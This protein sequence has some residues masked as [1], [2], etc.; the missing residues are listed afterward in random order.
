[1]DIYLLIPLKFSDTLLFF[2]DLNGWL[3]VLS[4]DKSSEWQ[5]QNNERQDHKICENY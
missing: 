2:K 1:M 5:S 4:P 3:R